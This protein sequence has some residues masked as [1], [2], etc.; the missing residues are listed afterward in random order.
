MKFKRNIVKK[1]NI[2]AKGL[3]MIKILFVC[4]GNICRST[5]AESVFQDL[6]RKRGLENKF[7]IDSA[8]TH[9]DEIGNP[10]HRGTREKLEREK[11]P[12]V[13]HRARLM[14]PEDGE[15]FDLLIGMDEANRRD[16]IRIVGERNAGKVSLLLDGTARPRPIADPWYTGDF[17]ETFR[18]ISEGTAALLDRLLRA[19]HGKKID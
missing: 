1:E 8:A 14:K 10:P 9:S 13:P 2:P 12:L 7:L 6:V 18:D 5:M 16:M 3:E 19:E 4:H 17:D 15:R 11:I